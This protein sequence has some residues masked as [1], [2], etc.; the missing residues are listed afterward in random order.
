VLVR[1]QGQDGCRK[2]GEQ[3]EGL[4]SEERDLIARGICHDGRAAMRVL[5]SRDCD[6]HEN[7]CS[8]RIPRMPREEIKRWLGPHLCRCTGY[9]KIVDAVELAGQSPPRRGIPEPDQSGHVGTSMISTKAPT[10][11]WVTRT[12]STT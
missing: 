7:G 1:R 10:R 9:T 5:H 2:E 3:L 11:R 4:P 6:A 8:I 12:T